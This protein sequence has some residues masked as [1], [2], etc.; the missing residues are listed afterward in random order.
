LLFFLVIVLS[1]LHERQHS[2]KHRNSDGD[3]PEQLQG[4]S[5][6]RTARRSKRHSMSTH[7]EPAMPEKENHLMEEADIGSGE[8]KSGEKDTQKE[9]SKVSNPQMQ[10]ESADDDLEKDP[11]YQARSKRRPER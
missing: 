3:A 4:A 8:K 5:N 2:R 7:E 9:V 1:C 10:R 11:N 6:F